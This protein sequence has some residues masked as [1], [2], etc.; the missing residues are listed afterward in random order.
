MLST[1]FS[2]WMLTDHLAELV[3]VVELGYCLD[4]PPA[5]SICSLW[6]KQCRGEP[7]PHQGVGVVNTFLRI[8]RQDSKWEKCKWTNAPSPELWEWN[9]R[10]F[11]GREKD[12]LPWW[13][14]FSQKC[15]LG[16]TCLIITRGPHTK[17]N[18]W[19]LLVSVSGSG[20]QEYAF[21]YFFFFKKS[22]FKAS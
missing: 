17:G 22:L 16:T 14:Y 8:E 15:A 1:W 2:L 10:G 20:A 4:I 9:R 12:R 3:V 13:L 18:F 6:K 7:S 21:Y 19:T 11:L 5:L